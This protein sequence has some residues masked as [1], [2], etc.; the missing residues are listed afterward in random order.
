[1]TQIL[2]LPGRSHAVAQH[3]DGSLD[4]LAPRLLALCLL[5]PAR[6]LAAVGERERI[7]ELAQL[8]LASESH[9]ERGRRIHRALFGIGLEVDS[10]R[11]P[12]LHARRLAHLA[13]EAE[14]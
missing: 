13:V 3:F 7:E 9:R 12:G 5:D 10:D 2:C 14:V 11:V 1:M 4:P 6:V 8:R